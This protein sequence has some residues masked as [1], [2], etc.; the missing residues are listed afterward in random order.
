VYQRGR[1]FTVTGSKLPGVPGF[2]VDAQE[3]HYRFWATHFPPTSPQ[4]RANA[5]G[6]GDGEFS[7]SDADALALAH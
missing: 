1:N 6:S 2:V 4:R 7:L 5:V 3:I